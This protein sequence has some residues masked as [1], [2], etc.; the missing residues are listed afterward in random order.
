SVT[1]VNA[2]AGGFSK[3]TIFVSYTVGDRV[4]DIVLRQVPTG[5]PTNTLRPEFEVLKAVWSPELPICEPLWIEEANTE[6]G[7]PYFASR[8]APGT[9]LGSVQGAY[10]PVDASV[11]SSLAGVLAALHQRDPS[12]I[13]VGPAPNMRGLAEIAAAIDDLEQRTLRYLGE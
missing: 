10:G 11:I 4:E 3:H 6:L 12:S 5:Q 2:V 13:G 9:P 1:G 7:G 8:R